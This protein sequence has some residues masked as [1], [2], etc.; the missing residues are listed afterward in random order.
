VND[1]ARRRWYAGLL[2]LA[3]LLGPGE[4]GAG[5]QGESVAIPAATEGDQRAPAIAAANGTTAYAW[6]E[7]AGVRLRLENGPSAMSAEISVSTGPGDG[8]DVVLDRNGGA[9]LVAWHAPDGT[10]A[11][12]G[13][14]NR[15][16]HFAAV[17]VFPVLFGSTDVAT[18]TLD[19]T[20]TGD[21]AAPSVGLLDG[22][23]FAVAWQGPRGTG[24]PADAPDIRVG[25]VDVAVAFGFGA[26]GDPTTAHDAT[27]GAQQAPAL[28]ADG[29][30]RVAVAWESADADGTGIQLAEASG[31]LDF[32]EAQPVNELTAGDQS[33]PAAAM[34]AGAVVV[35]WTD[36]GSGG[37]LGSGTEIRTRRLSHGEVGA[38]AAPRGDHDH[39]AVRVFANGDAVVAWQDGTDD[40][41]R[42]AYRRFRSTDAGQPIGVDV[43]VDAG[44][45]SAQ[46]VPRLAAVDA[47]TF[48]V[49]FEGADA[50]GTGGVFRRSFVFNEPPTAPP[51]EHTVAEDTPVSGNVLTDVTD[52]DGDEPVLTASL[53]AAPA[54]GTVDLAP[55]GS[56]TYTPAANFHGHDSFAYR[57]SDP[58]GASDA[59]AVTVT[60]TPANDGP[61]A[62]PDTY[63]VLEGE[64]LTVGPDAGFLSNDGDVDGDSLSV[65][66]VQAPV[67]GTLTHPCRPA[68]TGECDSAPP[69]DGSFRYRP[70]DGFCGEPDSFRYEVRDPSMQA[71][72]ADVT[73]QV[74]CRHRAPVP[75][76]DVFVADPGA[77]LSVPAPG[78]LANDRAFAGTQ[79]SVARFEQPEHG[80]VTLLADGSFTYEAASG[81]TGFDRFTYHVRDSEPAPLESQAPGTVTVLVGVGGDA[82]VTG[83]DAYRTSPGA[84]LDVPVDRG[85]LANDTD[86]NGAPLIAALVADAAHGG[87]RL[88][89]DGS[90]TYTPDPAPPVPVP[91]TE[92]FQG[93]DSFTY[94][95]SNGTSRTAAT[96]KLLV[97][98]TGVGV[99]ATDDWYVTDAGASIAVS[100]PG[101][102]INDVA[103]DGGPVSIVGDPPVAR[104]GFL[105]FG[106]GDGSLIYAPERGFSGVDVL[107]YSVATA[108]GRHTATATVAIIVRPPRLPPGE[109]PPATTIPGDPV[110]PPPPDVVVVTPPRLEAPPPPAPVV[111]RAGTPA[112]DAT[113]A[114]PAPI[115]AVAGRRA[116]DAADLPLVPAL[117]V[118]GAVVAAAA[119][120][121][122]LRERRGLPQPS[123]SRIEVP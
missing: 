45:D 63:S 120:T 78:V 91:G 29:S 61:A 66:I 110:Q 18:G 21:Q 79:L 24:N 81:F 48:T 102:L 118:L 11:D 40:G 16:V 41:A 13:A 4:V 22:G 27:A 33:R 83:G 10:T 71:A 112:P 122:A 54:N 26:I 114:P 51:Y 73:I 30:G 34:A 8:V 105:N 32:G 60:V 43:P 39:A 100:A 70:T 95:A 47:T 20:L 55:D 37:D 14:P 42:A 80:R 117:G 59:D 106:T 115:V 98:G 99:L 5:P 65:L 89:A 119:A 68:V 3:L 121:R 28:G 101:V 58:A 7:S 113:A 104:H 12:D 76:D 67:H 88:A 25:T 96:V 64:T 57:V 75:V 116:R 35:A 31:D 17:P 107:R 108:G 93:V 6:A 111:V 84:P 77:A 62:A 90:F 97:G 72:T 15:A 94:S 19:S 109:P 123:V 87:V 46:R 44:R 23:R 50:D 52:P 56:Y 1:G 9:A 74:D 86:P 82:P 36:H 2:L 92:A 53:E 38:S 103:G 49:V 69:E 85:V